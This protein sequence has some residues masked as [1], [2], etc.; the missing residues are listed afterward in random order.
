VS[1]T[2]ATN[3]EH[4]R[5]LS[6]AVELTSISKRFGAT[7]AL[8]GVTVT[9]AAARLCAVLGENGAGKS[10]LLRIIAGLS[11]PTHGTLT[12]FGSSDLRECAPDLGYMPHASLLYDELTGI[13]NLRYFA[14]LYGIRDH[15][16]LEHAIET[17]GLDPRLERR[18]GQ[19]SQGMRQRLSLAR[20]M[21]HDPR[22]LLLDEPFSNVDIASAHAMV[23]LLGKMRDAGKTVLVVTHQP[24][25]LEG[26]ADEALF[27]AGGR[28][29]AHK[30]WGEW[31]LEQLAAEQ[32]TI[33]IVRHVGEL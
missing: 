14:G 8:H 6:P 21:V 23:A 9:F 27:L 2:P 10:T 20:A 28:V 30:Q 32:M 24:S 17:V 4:P 18:V 7:V 29:R 31:D 16:V 19:Y 22:L 26:V 33:R 25:L 1:F 13:E 15:G 5:S 12:I 3:G 11:E